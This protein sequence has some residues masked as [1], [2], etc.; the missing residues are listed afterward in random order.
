MSTLATPLF[1]V[2]AHPVRLDVKPALEGRNR[3]TTAF[4]LFLAL[5]H[6][7]L[8][9]G[10]IAGVVSWTWG[11]PGRDQYQGGFG[12]GVFG[13][14]AA[15]C[16]LIAWFA[17]LF[18]GRYPEGL[19][20]LVA[21]YMRWRVRAIAYA[22]L[23][24]DDY[25]PFGDG[26]YPVTLELDRPIAPRDRLT[27]AF[28]LFLSIPHLVVIWALGVAWALTTI[29]AWFAILFTGRYPAGL[30]GFGVGVL[31]WTTRVESY[32]LLLRD[33]YPPF[34]LT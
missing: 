17:I 23:L 6:L 11:A 4:R 7:L 30:Y 29:V 21:Y 20:S 9:G 8:V 22:A 14:V 33:E 2:A 1:P 16:A 12:G 15:M 10:P 27:V 25:P 31:R 18:T 32:L 13:A 5:P 3:L 34:S 28:R 19:W 24:R 26:A